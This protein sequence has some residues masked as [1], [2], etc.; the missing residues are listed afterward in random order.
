VGVTADVQAWVN[1]ET[2]YGW[3]MT[4][5]DQDLNGS[6]S[7]GTDGMAFNPSET[8][9]VDDR[10]R[11]RVRWVPAAT[12]A[13][14]FRQGVNGYTNAA[15]T[16]IRARALDADTDFSTASSVF[17]DWAVDGGGENDEQV[18]LRFDN[19]IGT[20]PGQIPPGARV[21]AAMLDLATVIGNGYGDGGQIFAMLMP[22]QDTNTWNA[23]GGVQADGVKAA[24]T[25]TASAGSPALNPNVCGGYLS[26]DVTPD[27]QTWADGARPNYGWAILPWPNGGDGWGLSMSEAAD[28][29]DRP[30]LRVFYTPR[31]VL[32]PLVRSGN[33]LQLQVRAA[34]G[35]TYQVLRAPALGGP[36]TAIGIVNIGDD[37]MGSFIDATPP[38]E[39]G[40]YKVAGQ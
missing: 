30:R 1:G 11:L 16:R 15:D 36:W 38:A 2:N 18:L 40:F 22:W 34:A 20:N 6:W 8:P 29:R 14:S 39:A 4:S 21:D 7:R 32:L 23:L 25:S 24:L 33:G 5:W 3:A 37:G 28:E 27:V 26:F 10:P 13:V 19:L 31:P 35:D 12:A 17:V 9:A